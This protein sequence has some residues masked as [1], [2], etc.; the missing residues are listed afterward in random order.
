MLAGREEAKERRIVS[1]TPA[2]KERLTIC[3][4]KVLESR[5]WARKVELLLLCE[6]SE[7]TLVKFWLGKTSTPKRKCQRLW[8]PVVAGTAL[9][10]GVGKEAVCQGGERGGFIDAPFGRAA[11]SYFQYKSPNEMGE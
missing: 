7:K 8:R 2:K 1:A 9:L 5:P 11:D 3:L 10:A 6:L 4:G